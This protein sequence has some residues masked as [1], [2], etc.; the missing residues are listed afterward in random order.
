M[1][2]SI[3]LMVVNVLNDQ[4]ATQRQWL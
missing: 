1:D 4:N 3:L 2:L